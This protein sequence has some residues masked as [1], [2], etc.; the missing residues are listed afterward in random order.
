MPAEYEVPADGSDVYRC[1]VIPTNLTEDRYVAAVEYQPGNRRVVHHMLG[2]IDTTGKA[3]KRD[4]GDDGP[5]YTCFSGPGIEIHGDLGGWAPGNEPSRLPE[6]VGRLLPRGADVVVQVHYHPSGKPE[7]DRSRIGVIFS[8]TPIRQTMQWSLAGKFD[9]KIPPGESNYE[10]KAQ[11]RI[12]VD[13]E[14]LAVTPHMHMIGR[15]MRMWVTFP[16]GR[17]QDL[18]II[19]DWDFSWQNTYYFEQPLTLPQGSVLKLIA[20]FDNSEQNPRNPNKPPKLVKF[21]EGT[22]DEMCIGFIALTKKGQDL[23]QPGDKDDLRQII[24]K[25]FEELRQKV[26]KSREGARGEGRSD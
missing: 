21:G 18:I 20:H 4:E 16:D 5:G 9:L 12:P 19:P 8:K 14:A 23:T 15:D 1:F 10:A 7:T 13:V 24:D 6:G 11:W 26:R 3:R 2:Y 25:D 17:D 22:N